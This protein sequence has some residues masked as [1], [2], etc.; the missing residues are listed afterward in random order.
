MDLDPT[1][2][3]PGPWCDDSKC[4]VLNGAGEIYV[5]GQPEDAEY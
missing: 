5:L 3:D 2:T 1:T 4:E